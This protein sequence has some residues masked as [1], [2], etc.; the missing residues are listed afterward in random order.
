VATHNRHV[1]PRTA[2]AE[3]V[4]NAFHDRPVIVVATATLPLVSLATDMGPGP[5]HDLGTGV[6][7]E[8]G[9]WGGGRR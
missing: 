7:V 6:A 2:R 4:G 3:L 9:W 5:C 8:C 1:A